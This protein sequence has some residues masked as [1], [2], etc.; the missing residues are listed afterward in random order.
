[1][2]LAAA[3]WL[4]VTVQ[5]HGA[6]GQA[7]RGAAH[8]LLGLHAARVVLAAQHE[9]PCELQHWA[10]VHR[11]AQEAADAWQAGFTN[12]IGSDSGSGGLQLGSMQSDMCRSELFDLAMLCGL[13]GE[14]PQLRVVAPN[15]TKMNGAV[16]IWLV[17]PCRSASASC[18]VRQLCLALTA[19]L[20]DQHHRL[21]SAAWQL[22]QLGRPDSHDTM[23]TQTAC[24]LCRII[25]PLHDA[26]AAEVSDDTA[27][28][29]EAHNDR[30]QSVAQRI[31]HHQSAAEAALQAG[32][33]QHHL[34][35][36]LQGHS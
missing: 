15:H 34:Q 24:T 29:A 32:V 22:Q 21:H 19:G 33:D 13:Q 2:R 6:A 23:P 1:M 18:N 3:Q 16:R 20:S 26:G 31:L 14:C 35:R 5:G 27:D 12:S 36:L 17:L 25:A 30:H 10:T 4:L 28:S 8:C 9:A 7:A 11:H